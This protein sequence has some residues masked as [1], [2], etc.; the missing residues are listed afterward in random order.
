ML[1][2]DDHHLAS[3]HRPLETQNNRNASFL[4]KTVDLHLIPV[5]DWLTQDHM[6]LL[7]PS[8]MITGSQKYHDPPIRPSRCEPTLAAGVTVPS[9]LTFSHQSDRRFTFE[10]TLT[11]AHMLA[12]QFE[13]ADPASM[14]PVEWGSGE[15]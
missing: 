13:P 15:S 1:Q 9:S 10:H 4:N 6:S 14:F 5:L 11:W 2:S 7:Q 3:C 12:L 8:L